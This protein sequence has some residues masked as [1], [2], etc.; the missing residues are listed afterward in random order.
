MAFSSEKVWN[1]VTRFAPDGQR[2]SKTMSDTY[3]GG[4]GHV[5]SASATL[6][7]TVWLVVTGSS[8]SYCEVTIMRSNC[9]E[10]IATSS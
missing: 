4:S 9:G 1:S 3:S 6:K 10:K 5:H 8:R 7:M 2:H